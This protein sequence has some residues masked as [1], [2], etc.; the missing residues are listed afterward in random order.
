MTWR[1][2]LCIAGA[3]AISTTSAYHIGK[4]TGAAA[5]RA[6]MTAAA[7]ADARKAAETYRQKELDHER[8]I[9]DLRRT[10]AARDAAAAA[11]DGAATA[12]LRAGTVRWRVRLAPANCSPAAN[13]DTTPARTDAPTTGGL[14]PEIAASLFG[15]AAGGDAAIRQLT[16]LQD[17]TGSAVRLCSPSAGK[18]SIAD[19]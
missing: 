13:P 3:L 1:F 14:A 10:F 2:W 11:N 7:Q 6:T 15:I 12:A 19:F 17:W 5:T 4:R 8:T 16:A 9:S 18:L